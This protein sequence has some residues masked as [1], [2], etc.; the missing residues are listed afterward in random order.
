MERGGR[1]RRPREQE[2]IELTQNGW[3]EPGR[4]DSF[5]CTLANLAELV[6]GCL[7]ASKARSVIEVGAEHGFFTRELL[8]WGQAHGAERITAIDPFPR[9]ELLELHQL[10]PELE[11][12]RR[13]SHEALGEV[14]LADV[15]ILD[16]DH[17]YFTVSEELRLIT[18]RSHGSL[19]L[20]ILHDIGWPLGRRDSYHDR[21]ALPDDAVATGAGPGFLDP[22]E[23]GLSERGL[24]YQCVAPQAG[25]PRN[26]VLTA[27]DDYLAD[28]TGLRFAR[29]PQFFGLGII[30]SEGAPWAGDIAALLAPLDSNPVLERA[31]EKRIEHLVAE[32]RL[33]QQIDAM[34]SQDYELQYLL[35][36]MLQSSAFTLA[37]RVSRLKQGGKP[38]FSRAEVAAALARVREDNDL[39]Q[40]A[41]SESRRE[42]LRRFEVELDDPEPTSGA[43]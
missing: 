2:E 17:N 33:M 14:K 15:V 7:D 31:E 21:T 37:E 43:A 5:D 11:L 19:P 22:S 28:Q 38:M 6:L 23:P 9:D 1:A 27:I 20:I 13:P 36:T 30:W 3:T 26:G 4:P 42:H 25:G 24:Y 39:L 29:V 34:R 41:E 10:H 32:F 12:V 18:E 8:A 16:G 35:S 40:G